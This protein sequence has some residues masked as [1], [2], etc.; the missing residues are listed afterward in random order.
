MLSTRALAVTIALGLLL[1][2]AAP[3]EAARSSKKAK[4]GDQSSKKKADK[5]TRKGA[6]ASLR[7][8]FAKIPTPR[9]PGAARLRL[10]FKPS[11]AD[12]KGGRLFREGKLK[13]KG[14]AGP[15]LKQ[16][17]LAST[18]RALRKQ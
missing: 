8:R 12:G 5:K 4:S 18:K 13:A 1:V 17:V 6:D 16:K 14:P 9:V 2:A 10:E 15:T 11:R 7:G 3:A